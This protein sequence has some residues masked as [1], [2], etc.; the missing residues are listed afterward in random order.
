MQAAFEEF[1]TSEI[2]YKPGKLAKKTTTKTI[3][4][5]RM[6]RSLHSID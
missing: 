5:E 4:K 2:K 6:A 3:E 1:K